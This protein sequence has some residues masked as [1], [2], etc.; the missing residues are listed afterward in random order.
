MYILFNK[1][2][3]IA[4][5]LVIACLWGCSVSDESS[6]ESNDAGTGLDAG[7]AD[8]DA[9]PDAGDGDDAG[10]NHDAGP[11]Y[12]PCWSVMDASFPDNIELTSIW[13]SSLDNVFSAGG[14]SVDENHNVINKGAVF[15]FDGNSWKKMSLPENVSF[16]RAINGKRWNSVYAA[17][18]DSV[19]LQYNGERWSS[20]ELMPN[21]FD[22]NDLWINNELNVYAA[23][24][25][26]GMYGNVFHFNE[27]EWK[28][29]LGLDG[30]G[31]TGI[32][33]RSQKDIFVSGVGSNYQSSESY[34]MHFNGIEWSEINLDFD[35]SSCFDVWGNSTQDVFLTCAGLSENLFLFHLHNSSWQMVMQQESIPAGGAFITGSDGYDVFFW[36]RY[37]DFNEN[38]FIPGPLYHFDGD[39][40][41][42]M[43]IPETW[44]IMGLWAASEGEAFGV[45]YDSEDEKAR[46]FRYSCGQ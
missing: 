25:S 29:I 20:M 4:L 34:L 13:G 35:I 9:G 45:G 39:A 22:I 23:G 1:T 6:E 10:A 15:F 24:T 26:L 37:Y 12:D 32:W 41:S 5:L 3:Q 46:I 43:N 19:V 21:E 31:L 44:I 27:S 42:K 2:L 18:N 30:I 40:W 17:G 11:E 7:N 16:L 8:S 36:G 33:G 14:W 28:S 38:S